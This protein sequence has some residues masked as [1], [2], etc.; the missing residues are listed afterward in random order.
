MYG[1]A[2][3]VVT[4]LMGSNAWEVIDLSL[5]KGLVYKDVIESAREVSAMIQLREKPDLLI[6]LSHSGIARGDE[7]IAKEGVFDVIFSGHQHFP[8]IRQW[9]TF[10][11]SRNN[12]TQSTIVHPGNWGGNY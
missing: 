4:A 8:D 2:K 5:R 6:C 12:V 7:D 10:P 9:E 11:N 3:I 1:E